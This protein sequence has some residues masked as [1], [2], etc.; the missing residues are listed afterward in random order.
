MPPFLSQCGLFL[1]IFLR[2][3]TPPDRRKANKEGSRVTLDN[4]EDSREDSRA[5]NKLVSQ[6]DMD[7]EDTTTPIVRSWVSVSR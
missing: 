7:M 1:I 4:R 6:V 3:R 5:D 2:R